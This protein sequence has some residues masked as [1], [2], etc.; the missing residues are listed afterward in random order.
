MRSSPA[1]PTHVLEDRTGCRRAHG[2]HHGHHHRSGGRQGDTPDRRKRHGRWARHA[3]RL[4]ADPSGLRW[5][6]PAGPARHQA[7]GC[8]GMAPVL[9]GRR[10]IPAAEPGGLVRHRGPQPALHAARSRSPG[11]AVGRGAGG[12]GAVG[13]AGPRSTGARGHPHEPYASDQ[14]NRGL[15]VDVERYREEDGRLIVPALAPLFS[16]SSTRMLSFHLQDSTWLAFDFPLPPSPAQDTVWSEP[17]PLRDARTT[18]NRTMWSAVRLRY[19]VVQWGA[20][21]E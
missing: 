6:L 7:R 16:R 13:Y 11:A 1:H 17:A 4:R 5:R 14:D 9:E 12:A 10:L 3:H 21:P 18:G 2:P 15:D 8:R 20:A 19:R